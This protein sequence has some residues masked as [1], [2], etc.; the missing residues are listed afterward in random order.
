VEGFVR[1]IIGWREYVRGLYWWHMP[2]YL[3]DNALDAQQ[4]LPKLYWTGD[5][6]MN[7]LK[8]VV[9]DTLAHGY[10]HHIQRL[11]ITGLFALLFGVKPKA[12]HAWY[13]AVYVDAVE[14]V[15]VPNTIGMS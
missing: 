5:T 3:D 1:Q 12:V 11:M 4:D 6:E 2:Q 7:C 10:A 13:L 15:E 9:R 8:H 14:W